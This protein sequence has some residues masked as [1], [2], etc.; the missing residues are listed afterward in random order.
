MILARESSSIYTDILAKVM[1]AAASS[2]LQLS[3]LRGAE[4]ELGLKADG[5]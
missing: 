1:H 4:G 3:D 5:E 2:G